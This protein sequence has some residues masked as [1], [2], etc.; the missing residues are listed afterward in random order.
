MSLRCSNKIQRMNASHAGL[1][2]DCKVSAPDL[3]RLAA[4]LPAP[5]QIYGARL[6]GAG[7][8]GA[9]VA[10]CRPDAVQAVAYQVL[11]ACAAGDSARGVQRK[12]ADA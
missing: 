1:R 5:A 11:G 10:L 8:G 2:D 7:F 6:T 4:W 12:P 3:E 9:C